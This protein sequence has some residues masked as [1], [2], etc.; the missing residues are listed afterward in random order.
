MKESLLFQTRL[1]VLAVKNQYIPVIVF[2]FYFL[3]MLEVSEEYK[4][5]LM[6]KLEANPFIRLQDEFKSYYKINQH[7]VMSETYIAPRQVKLP[8]TKEGRVA[9]Y[10]Y[11]SVIDTI[12]A[13]LSDPAF[14]PIK[15]AP[16]GLLRDVIDGSAFK[17]NKFF[18]DNPSAVPVGIYSDAFQ[19]SNPLGA[20]KGNQKV[21]NVYLALLNMDKSLRSRTDNLYLVMVVKEKDLKLNRSAV[22]KPLIDDLK[23]LEEGVEIGGNIVK[24]GL[25]CTFGDN[26]EQHTVGGFSASFSSRDVCRVCHQQYED[27]DKVTGIPKAPLW[28][29]SEYDEAVKKIVPGTKGEFGLNWNCEF[30]VLKAFH[31]IGHMPLDPLH[32]WLEKVGAYD[33]LSIVKALVSSGLFSLSAYNAALRNVALANYEAADRP[34]P[35]SNNSE[36]LPGKALSVALEIRVMPILILRLRLIHGGDLLIDVSPLLKLLS[37]LHRINEYMLADAFN[38]IDADKFQDLLVEYFYQR[39]VC[40]E[41]FGGFLQKTP[42]YHYLGRVKKTCTYFSIDVAKLAVMGDCSPN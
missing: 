15:P 37:Y 28:T 41:L 27:L 8:P 22:Y 13:V 9:S 40:E 42:R 6:R 14:K 18:Q 34:P 29:V 32:D 24:V 7:A 4:L 12:K 3:E 5:A 21:V 11:I 31:P 10:Q 33:G 35:I 38:V 39:K 16:E 19:M 30:N 23:K 26:L 20:A 2:Y 36:R 17:E 1:Q 25:L